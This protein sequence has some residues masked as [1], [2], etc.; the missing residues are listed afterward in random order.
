M[1]GIGVESKNQLSIEER[2]QDIRVI[3]NTHAAPDF[4]SKETV[5]RDNVPV[6]DKNCRNEKALT[7]KGGANLVDNKLKHNKLDVA[8]PSVLKEDELQG[9]KTEAVYSKRRTSTVIHIWQ[10]VVR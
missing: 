9:L 4:S 10:Y 5:N 6:A 8:P 2:E 3:E 1:K 7:P